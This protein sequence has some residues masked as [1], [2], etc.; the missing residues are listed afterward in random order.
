MQLGVG[1]CTK[2][3]SRP[4]NSIHYCALVVTVANVTSGRL[5]VATNRNPVITICGFS[6]NR[7]GHS[8]G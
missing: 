6:D 7:N 5:A 2:L 3:S 8:T 1:E 4:H